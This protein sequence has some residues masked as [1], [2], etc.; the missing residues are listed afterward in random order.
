MPG[1]EKGLLGG[2]AEAVT[3]E[4]R[5]L[6]THQAAQLTAPPQ[7]SC[8]VHDH[9]ITGRRSQTVERS[10]RLRASLGIDVGR[11]NV[12]TLGVTGLRLCRQC[13]EVGTAPMI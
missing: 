6:A 11:H 1:V 9:A 7:S 3:G 10:K 4:D 13:V 12:T 5:P 2:C 8:I